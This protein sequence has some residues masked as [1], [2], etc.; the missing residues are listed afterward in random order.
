MT[1]AVKMSNQKGRLFI[2]ED[3]FISFLSI[4]SEPIRLKILELLLERDYYNVSDLL[5]ILNKS[6]TLVSHHLR[7]LKEL[8]LI[9]SEKDTEDPRRTNYMLVNRGLI[10][11]FFESAKEVLHYACN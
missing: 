7:I 11:K 2:E 10:E 9:I 6:Q 5:A 1:L 4:I 3:D 8:G